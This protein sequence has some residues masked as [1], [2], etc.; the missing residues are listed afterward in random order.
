MSSKKRA[1][2]GI[3][4]L[5]KQIKLHKEKLKEAERN[6]NIGLASYY[7]KEIQHFEQAIKKLEHRL[8]PK[9]RKKKFTAM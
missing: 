5:E 4:S 8:Q 1:K 9:K 2:K 7:E 3:E 6:E